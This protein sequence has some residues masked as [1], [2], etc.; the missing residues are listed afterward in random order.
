MRI[1]TWNVWFGA[2]EQWPRCR[3]LVAELGA[4]RPEVICLQEV[5]DPFLGHLRSTEWIADEYTLSDRTG[6]SYKAYGVVLLTR[7]DLRGVTYHDLPTTMDR[8]L[9]VAELDT[10]HG[11]FTVA[12]AHLESLGPST[13][14]RIAQLQALRPVLSAIPHDLALCGDC[15]FDPSWEEAQHVDPL[16]VDLWPALRPGE[17]GDT[18]DTAANP[19]LFDDRGSA[20]KRVRFD[21]I[22]LRAR[23]GGW[24][25]K[26]IELLGTAA[27]DPAQPRLR[28]SDH[29]GL[30][31]TLEYTGS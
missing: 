17:P 2:H 26:H 21:R 19:M 1:A 29:F 15:N 5:T 8:R 13:A 31:A 10:P 24:R 11:P 20:E 23:P 14:L 22:F 7:L 16:L 4:L 6:A 9:L 30:M 3:A 18:V 25:P 28:P 12:T 27:F